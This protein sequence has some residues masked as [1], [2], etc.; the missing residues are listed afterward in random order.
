[1]RPPTESGDVSV[2][3]PYLTVTR[4][5]SRTRRVRR[6]GIPKLMVGNCRLAARVQRAADRRSVQR[7]KDELR[8]S[9]VG[10]AL[11]RGAERE[12]KGRAEVAKRPAGHLP[13]AGSTGI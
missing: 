13:C 12:C 7:N 1:M 3:F 2:G 10:A 5:F 6:D 8:R 4:S 9:A 11:T